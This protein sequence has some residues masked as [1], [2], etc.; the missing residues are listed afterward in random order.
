MTIKMFASRAPSKKFAQ[1]IQ[2]TQQNQI[3]VEQICC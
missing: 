3:K 2:I 1:N